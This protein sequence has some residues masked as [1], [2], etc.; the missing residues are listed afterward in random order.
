MT[1]T[2][3]KRRH[4]RRAL[5]VRV[6]SI[7]S[8]HRDSPPSPS[9]SPR[10]IPFVRLARTSCLVEIPIYSARYFLPLERRSNVTLDRSRKSNRRTAYNRSLFAPNYILLKI[11]TIEYTGYS[12]VE[13]FCNNQIRTS[14]KDTPSRGIRIYIY[15]CV[16]LCVL[17]TR[18]RSRA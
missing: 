15:V 18:V 4:A 16:S 9:P 1:E 3:R 7:E 13:N 12:I 8:F 17:C 14:R 11:L 6:A 5:P 2:Q 10:I